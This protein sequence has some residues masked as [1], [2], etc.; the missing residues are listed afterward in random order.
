MFDKLREMKEQLTNAGNAIRFDPSHFN[1]PLAEQI[2]WTPLK[3]GGSNFRT[4]K[5]FEE[6]GNRVGFKPTIGAR[7]FSLIFILLGVGI[8]IGV[9]YGSIQEGVGLM[10]FEMLFVMLFGLIFFGVGSYIFYSY[11]KPIVF[12]KISGLYWKGFKQPERSVSRKSLKNGVRINDIYALQII[13]EYISGDKKN[14]YSYELNLV[15]GN[16]DRVNVIDH[17][18]RQKLRSDADVLSK[19]LGKP[20]WDATGTNR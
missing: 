5:L 19:F 14:Y 13:E 8:P 20:V 2:R 6:G 12:D 4:H 15:L 10:Q 9:G 18:N 17:G 16:G 7:I 1:D 3:G 11:S